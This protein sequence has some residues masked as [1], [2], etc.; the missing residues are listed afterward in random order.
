[1]AQQLKEHG[2]PVIVLDSNEKG[3][4]HARQRGLNIVHAELDKVDSNAMPYLETARAVICTSSDLEYNY[5]V[6]E[7]ARKRYGIGHVV[8]QVGASDE[9]TRFKTLGAQT[10]DPML[11]QATMIKKLPWSYVIGYTRES[12]CAICSYPVIY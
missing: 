3:L 12:T 9:Q 5:R 8:V 11:N 7:L 6:C 10:L 2:E 4:S 1:V